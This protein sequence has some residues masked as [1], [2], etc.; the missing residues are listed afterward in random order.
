M[1]WLSSI[2]VAILTGVVGMLVSGFI[3]NLAVG[4]YRI[5]SFE[6]GSGYFV[7]GMALLGLIG[8][9]VIGI[10]AARFVA[11][12][13]EPGFLKA[14]GAGVGTVGILGLTIGGGARL[15]ADI[16]PTIDGE[17]LLLAVELRWPAA[18]STDPA[19]YPG[20][21]YTRLGTGFGRVIRDSREGPLFVDQARKE[22]GRWVVPGLVS[23]FTSRGERILDVGIG[24]KLLGGFIIKLP[25]NPGPKDREWSEW[26]PRAKP[27][28]PPLPDGFTYRFRVIL[29]TEVGRV[30]RVGPFSVETVAR[31]FFS[32]ADSKRLA[33]MSSFRIHHR[34][35]PVPQLQAAGAVSVV[36][37]PT[38]A[39]LVQT[40]TD[41]A[42]D[43]CF[44]V[45][46]AADSLVVTD[47]TTCAASITAHPLT[48]DPARIA[49]A[50]ALDLVPG[51]IDFDTFR[52]PGLFELSDGVFDSRTLT[53]TP[54]TAPDEPNRIN[55]LPPASLSPDERS[56][57]WFTHHGD[58]EHPVLGVTDWRSDST[59]VVPID[60]TR[61]RY[62][63][64]HEIRP[65]WVDHHF[66]WV[67]GSDG[68][69]RLTPR[70]RFT[71]LPYRGQLTVGKPGDYA[72]Y[73]LRP[74]GKAL[75]QAMMDV[76]VTELGA[77]RMP[78]ELDGY[79]LVVRLDGKLI[80]AAVI[81]TGSY[82]SIG[83]D[84]GSTDPA[85]MSRVAAALDAAV[86]TGRYDSLFVAD[87]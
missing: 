12:G 7:V 74:G 38:P 28:S 64:Y 80:K 62:N 23:I 29:A 57:V 47:L 87:K 20:L 66:T 78:D 59:Y 46:E 49:A 72:A 75:R 3:A 37:G 84:Y 77:E 24:E 55:G 71:P 6:G 44:L 39:L 16:P 76:L 41:T 27:G 68:I 36:A 58:D 1:S 70:D 26:Y 54:V 60:R 85:L 83:M 81:E 9:A 15:L 69:D 5:S 25:R 4:W 82:L 31:Y 21:G 32:V 43:R 63:D 35:T 13:A 65:A 8:G 52:V 19:S 61:M 30:D 56:Y 50:R 33:A 86:A 79:Q 42:S 17:P 51:W 45:T 11:A 22:D 10:V 34:G 14:L 73:T 67:R 18:D 2:G 48:A 53:F 40:N